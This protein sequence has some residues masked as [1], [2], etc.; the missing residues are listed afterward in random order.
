MCTSKGKSILQWEDYNGL[1][2]QL[3]QIFLLCPS[4]SP[5][6]DWTTLTSMLAGEVL[7]KCS[8]S[9][10]PIC[11]DSLWS[12]STSDIFGYLKKNSEILKCKCLNE[13]GVCS[14]SGWVRILKSN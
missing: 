6:M 7:N 13:S 9:A 11:C 14:A 4:G 2:T 10:L 1:H 5:H 12:G 3:S 8:K